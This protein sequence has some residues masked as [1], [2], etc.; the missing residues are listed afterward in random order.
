M[1]FLLDKFGSQFWHFLQF[2]LWMDQYEW[3]WWHNWRF[4]YYLFDS[5]KFFYQYDPQSFGGTHEAGENKSTLVTNFGCPTPNHTPSPTSTNKIASETVFF[6]TFFTCAIRLMDGPTEG[7]MVEPV[8]GPTDG[9]TK[10][11]KLWLVKGQEIPW[12]DVVSNL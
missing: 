11:Q 4:F 12:S 2:P 7:P 5:G 8:V 6:A 9:D 3:N 1:V 10:S